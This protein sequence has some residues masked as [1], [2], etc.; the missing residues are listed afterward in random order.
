MKMTNLLALAILLMLSNPLWAQK[1][2][3]DRYSYSC[4]NCYYTLPSDPLAEDFKTYNVKANIVGSARSVFPADQVENA[5]EINGWKALAKNEKA[6]I[7][8]NVEVKPFTF[9]KTEVVDRKEETKDKDGKITGTKYFYAA[10]LSYEMPITYTVKDYT[11]KDYAFFSLTGNNANSFKSSEYSSGAAAR[12]YISNNRDNLR[13]KFINEILTE[14]CKKATYAITLRW[15]LTE[16][17]QNSM[18]WLM[19]SKKHPEQDSMQIMA[20][21]MKAEINK[22]TLSEKNVDFESRMKPFADYMNSL[23]NRYKTDEKADKKMRYAAYYN[24]AELY[25]LADNP[26]MMKKYAALLEKNDYDAKD[27]KFI[28]KE[29]DALAKSFELN[30]VKTRHLSFDTESFAG[31]K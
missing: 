31:P 18:M 13:D 7:S 9:L 11:G 14:S 1:V 16:S 5:I 17:S 27:A 25:K 20:K 29:A 28:I 12:E 15:G 24:L 4:S 30:K 6:H 26:E 21:F 22:M 8:I 23:L 19:D 3:L 2:D 10:V